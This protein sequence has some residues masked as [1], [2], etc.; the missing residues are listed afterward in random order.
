MVAPPPLESDCAETEKLVGGCS[1]TSC[2]ESSYYVVRDAGI[3]S[4]QVAGLIA[5]S[6]KARGGK[7][8]IPILA[9]S[10]GHWVLRHLESWGVS[11]LRVQVN[12]RQVHGSVITTRAYHVVD[13]SDNPKVGNGGTIRDTI[14]NGNG[15]KRRIRAKTHERDAGIQIAGWSVWLNQLLNF[16][17]VAH[18]VIHRSKKFLPNVKSDGNPT[19]GSQC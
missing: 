17:A 15:T 5:E 11:V 6:W 3:T 7:G 16:K 9:T 18:R 4:S 12:S 10:G 19:S 8:S 14:S 13:V 2:S 1:P